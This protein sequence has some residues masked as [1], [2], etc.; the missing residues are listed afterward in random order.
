MLKD[1]LGLEKFGNL[2]ALLDNAG[3]KERSAALEMELD[4]LREDPANPR[5]RYDEQAIQELAAS[6]KARG[7]IAPVSVR[8]D[9]ENP[10]K[11][12]IN[13]GHRRVRASRLAGKQTIPAVI[14]DDFS[15]EDQIIENIQRE[16]LDMRDIAD[17]IGRKVNQGLTQREIADK[18]GKSAAYVNQHAKLLN[19]SDNLQ[20][21]VQTGK[22]KDI[23][24]IN[25]LTKLEKQR[26]AAVVEHLQQDVE[27]SRADARAL[28]EK[29]YSRKSRARERSEKPAE[30]E[31]KP[32][33]INSRTDADSIKVSV[34]VLHLKGPARI[35][36]TRR[37][38]NHDHVWVRFDNALLGEEEVPVNRIKLLAI[39]KNVDVC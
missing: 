6:I 30:A 31:E 34:V 5:S 22:V 18:I 36:L 17:Y 1:S 24:A 29:I 33:K 4:R 20:E 13:H 39:E 25:E 23:T 15:D 38:Q 10:G 27:I 32:Q 21:A 3:K 2:S 37:P 35:I 19:L 16:N 12:I 9:P 26:P 7:V 14:N 28:K 8:N 11:F